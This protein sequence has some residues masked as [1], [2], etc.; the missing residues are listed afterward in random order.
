MTG[1]Q[2][3]EILK[4]FKPGMDN[5]IAGIILGLPMIGGGGT[6]VYFSTAGVIRSGGDLPFWAEK[7]WSWGAAGLCE[8][9]GIGLLTCGCCLIWWVRSLVSLRVRIGQNGFAVLDKASARYYGWDEI[10]SVQETHLYERPPILK[11]VAKYA[12]PK[13][14]SK[15]FIVKIKEGEQFGFDGTTIKGHTKLAQMLKQETEQRKIP[16]EIVEQ[17]A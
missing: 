9:M 4:Q 5:L 17:R 16:W 10:Q 13:V 8:V 3:G 2:L 7:T 14:L 1:D 12:I 15:S 11:G 6:A